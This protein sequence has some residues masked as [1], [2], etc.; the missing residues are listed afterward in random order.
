[1]IQ[2]N[3]LQ[4]SRDKVILVN[5]QDEVL[6][7]ADKEASHDGKGVLHRA[8]SVFIFNSKGELLLQQ[9]SKE[10]RLWP[11]FWSNSCCS[12]P[13]PEETYQAAAQRRIN[14][15]LNIKT[16]LKLHYKFEYQAEFGEAGSE[17]EMCAVLS[18]VCD[19]Q[20]K[21]DRNEI[22]AFRWI[23]ADKLTQEIKDNPD[24]F[25]PWFKMEWS[26]IKG[27]ISPMINS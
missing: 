12:H 6:G 7:F 14:E 26:E 11:M 18:G 1:M 22:E 20:P 5:S 10:K 19:D 9:R 25:T 21:I 3:V 27:G 24:I 2:A 15:E 4:I 13:T 17:H 16:P 23:S 8:F